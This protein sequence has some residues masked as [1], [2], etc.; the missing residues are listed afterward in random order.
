MATKRQA[1]SGSAL[2]RFRAEWQ[3]AQKKLAQ[4]RALWKA[5]THCRDHGLPEPAWLHDAIYQ[6]GCEEID[7]K[8]TGRP[9]DIINDAMILETFERYL[10]TGCTKVSA[11]K[12]TSLKYFGDDKRGFTV[13]SACKRAEDRIAKGIDTEGWYFKREYLKRGRG[14]DFASLFGLLMRSKNLDDQRHAMDEPT[15]KE[16]TKN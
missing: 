13:R 11:R 4:K 12:R 16:R 3:G 1:A 7:L 5:R 2:G 15:F 9:S 6:L 14:K 10:R 8:E